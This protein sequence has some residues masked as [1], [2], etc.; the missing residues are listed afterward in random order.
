MI[1][2]WFRKKKRVEHRFSLGK[3][4]LRCL[5]RG[6]QLTF[7]TEDI[8]VHLLLEDIGFRTIENMMINCDVSPPGC[9]MIESLVVQE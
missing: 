8:M 9:W 7:A 1:F 2:G 5:I 3:K 6:G 4:E